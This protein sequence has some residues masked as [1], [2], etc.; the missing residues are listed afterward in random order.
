MVT[1]GAD[2]HKATHT[3]VAIDEVG[4]PLGEVT[5]PATAAGHRELV[6]WASQ[7][8]ERRFALEDVRH[9]SRRLEA[10]LIKAGERVVRVPTR[11]MGQ[12]RRSGRTRGKSD[13]IDALATARAALRE[14]HLPEAVLEGIELSR[15]LG[16]LYEN[17][18]V[19]QQECIYCL[20]GLVGELRLQ[21]ESLKRRVAV[22]E[23]KLI[24]RH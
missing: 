18:V 3:V 17:R 21:N 24:G 20:F 19:P 5:V 4:R 7:F 15:R 16:D 11:L 1:L 14:E 13:S 6:A 23:R 10:D 12:A 8:E 22:L 9:L 2:T